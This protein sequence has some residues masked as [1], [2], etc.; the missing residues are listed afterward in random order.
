M[1]PTKYRPFSADPPAGF[2]CCTPGPYRR[3]TTFWA[4]RAIERRRAGAIEILLAITPPPGFVGEEDPLDEEIRHTPRLVAAPKPGGIRWLA[5]I[6]RFDLSR[7]KR[8]TVAVARRIDR[9]LMRGVL[10]DRLD[11]SFDRTD[12]VTGSWCR[13]WRAARHRLRA[14]V[15]ERAPRSIILRAD[16][17]DCFASIAP[18]TVERTL[19]SMGCH[20]AEVGAVVRVLDHFNCQGIRGL[21]IGPEASAV[22]AAAVLSHAD[23]ALVSLGAVHLRWV[24]DF[25]VFTHSENEAR[26]I[27][28]VLT[29]ALGDLALEPAAHK[30]SVSESACGQSLSGGSGPG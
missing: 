25:I 8:A 29:D 6:D 28:E 2:P 5:E 9:Q 14:E 1:H 17:R 23:A 11:R 13:P 24:D 12:P 18:G 26:V 16:V 4:G 27:L 3:G 15:A 10:A 20:P 19:L 21:P 30:T 7:Y 22:L